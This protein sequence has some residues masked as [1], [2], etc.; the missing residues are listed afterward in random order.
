MTI[1]LRFTRNR[2]EH[3]LHK[4]DESG[5]TIRLLGFKC[6]YCFLNWPHVSNDNGDSC[7]I[8]CFKNYL[9]S[10]NY[11]FLFC[12]VYLFIRSLPGKEKKS[13]YCSR[14]NEYRPFLFGLKV[15]G[16][17]G[18]LKWFPYSTHLYKIIKPILP[19]FKKS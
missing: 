13:W 17:S 18:V 1:H 9:I 10:K 8:N 4:H 14:T 12:W 7:S 11:A 6:P 19:I 2:S 15:W 16:L 5:E 3:S